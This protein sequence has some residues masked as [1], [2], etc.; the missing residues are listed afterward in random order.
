M[1]RMSLQYLPFLVALLLLPGLSYAQ[2]QFTGGVGLRHMRITEHDRNGQTLVQEDG[3]L[4]GVELRADYVLDDWR[5]GL[6]AEAYRRDIAYDGRTQGGRTFSTDT[7]TTQTRLGIMLG[8][9]IGES[10]DL[11]A[12]LEWDRWQRNIRGHSGVLGLDER[13]TSWRLLAG[14]G[15][16]LL[17]I[18]GVRI[19]GRALLVVAAPERLQVRFENQV[20]DNA[21]FS[22]KSAT[23]L[24]M[25]LDFRP[26]ATP[27]LT[28]TVGFDWL[29]VRR[30]EDAILRRSGAAVGTV[31]QPEHV[32]R[33]LDIKL[34][35]Q[36]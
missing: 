3:W 2:W 12:G 24:R 36:F 27:A 22:T 25:A 5:L 29:R 31:A 34:S 13:Y 11:L 17:Q 8:R 6:S 7:A 30:S 1:P 16:S 21:S 23:G 28:A 18:A 32:R 20:F 15:T 14:A 33:A 35:Y 19:D 26:V 4:P 10:T 9:R